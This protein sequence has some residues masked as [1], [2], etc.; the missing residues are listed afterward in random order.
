LAL[1]EVDQAVDDNVLDALRD[2]PQVVRA[3]ALQF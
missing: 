3:Q 2:L 1:I